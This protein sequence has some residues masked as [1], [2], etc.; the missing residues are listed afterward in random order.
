MTM[1]SNLAKCNLGGTRGG[2]RSGRA[3]RP[4][5]D[6]ARTAL[7]PDSD[8]HPQIQGRAAGWGTP[9]TRWHAACLGGG[10]PG[11]LEGE[12]R[13][14]ARQLHRVRP[15]LHPHQ[16]APGP[17]A[18]HCAP[19]HRQLPPPRQRR[20][21]PHV[22]GRAAPPAGHSQ[23][24]GRWARPAWA[25]SLAAAAR[26]SGVPR[27]QDFAPLFLR[28][29]RRRSSQECILGG[30]YCPPLAPC[31]PHLGHGHVE[32]HR[33]LGQEPADRGHARGASG[34]QCWQTSQASLAREQR[35]VPRP[36]KRLSSIGPAALC[37]ARASSG[38]HSRRRR[39]VMRRVRLGAYSRA[40]KQA[41]RP[42]GRQTWQGDV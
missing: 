34:R 5:R 23:A 32:R 28:T 37:G 39:G 27:T 36:L 18:Q 17:R 33:D 38:E 6:R 8:P 12:P 25:Q 19:Q 10:A 31:S 1:D 42:A 2:H 41:G 16:H 14:D 11:F 26:A 9:P 30:D 22:T 4:A 35:S 7:R 20:T 15:Q 13:H 29:R 40:A 3:W 21:P 24:R